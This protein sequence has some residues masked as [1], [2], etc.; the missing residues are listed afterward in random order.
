MSTS[1]HLEGYIAYLTEKVRYLESVYAQFSDIERVVRCRDCAN[2]C[3][4]DVFGLRTVLECSR[5]DLVV[6]PDGF[7]KWGK[8]RGEP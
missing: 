8:R 6:E 5:D 7:C 4:K 2:G 1:E 3:E